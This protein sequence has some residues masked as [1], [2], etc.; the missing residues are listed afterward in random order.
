MPAR[1]PP[2][3]PPPPLRAGDAASCLALAAAAR[4]PLG[5]LPSLLCDPPSMLM[6]SGVMATF[7]GVAWVLKTG[8]SQSSRVR[9]SGCR[10]PFPMQMRRRRPPPEQGGSTVPMRRGKSREK[11]QSYQGGGLGWVR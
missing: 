9:L 6:C 1:L 4:P 3:P 2:P 10:I 8:T 5:I 7:T 11:Q